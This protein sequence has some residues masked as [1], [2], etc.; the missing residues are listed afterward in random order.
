MRSERIYLENLGRWYSEFELPE[1]LVTI[2]LRSRSV[3]SVSLVHHQGV[4]FS[5]FSLCC[6][7]PSL[8]S[9]N[10][11]TESIK[12]SDAKKEIEMKKGGWFE[13]KIRFPCPRTENLIGLYDW[14]NTGRKKGI[15]WLCILYLKEYI[16]ACWITK[17]NK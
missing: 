3:T 2:S 7:S 6:T 13:F 4:L 14:M 16:L 15:R 17:K 8:P 12:G 10:E 9:Y 5:S 11:A 1:K